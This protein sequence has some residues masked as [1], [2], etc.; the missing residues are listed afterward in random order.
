MKVIAIL[1]GVGLFVTLSGCV[2]VR[3][4]ERSILADPSYALRYRS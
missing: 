2:T 3:P 4:E 1:F